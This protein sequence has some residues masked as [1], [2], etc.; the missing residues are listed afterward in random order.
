MKRQGIRSEK[1]L[2]AFCT[3]EK[4]AERTTGQAGKQEED[5]ALAMRRLGNVTGGERIWHRGCCNSVGQS[6]GLFMF[7]FGLRIGE[8][9]QPQKARRARRKE[10]HEEHEGH[11][12]EFRIADFGFSM[13][14]DDKR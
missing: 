11:E 7:E 12:E 4:E 9:K 1:S 10:N 6:K 14:R 5:N 2:G 8:E 13:E 3:V